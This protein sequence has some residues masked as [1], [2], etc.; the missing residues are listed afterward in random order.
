MVDEPVTQAPG[1]E[2]WRAMP[3]ESPPAFAAASAY[4]EMRGERSITGLARRLPK[5]RSLLVRWSARWEWVR[6]SVAYDAWIV[7]QQMREYQAAARAQALAWQ[8]RDTELRERQ[9]DLSQCMLNKVDKMLEFPLATVTTEGQ[10]LP[11]GRVVQRTVVKPARWAMGNT[12][13]MAEAAF[14]LARSAVRNEG[15]TV[16]ANP[17][18]KQES[19]QD[20]DYK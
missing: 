18:Q 4:F 17:D 2:A 20:E 5:T 11:D 9:F 19:W 7:E 10:T 16:E 15:S 8:Q 13:R 3:G 14:K 1:N 12:G 6:R